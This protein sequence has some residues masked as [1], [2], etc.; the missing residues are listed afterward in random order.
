MTG[1]IKSYKGISP[2]IHESAFIAD[3]AVI[4]G[5]VEIGPESSIWY[6]CVLRGDLNKIRIGARTNI[7]DGTIIHV[8]AAT[9]NWEGIPTLIGDRVNVGHKAL[10]H[11][12]TVEDDAFIGMGSILLD[13]SLV[14]SGAMV[15]AGALVTPNKRVLKGELW[16]G[17]PAKCMRPL[18]PDELEYFKVVED[19]YAR[20]G[21]EHKMEQS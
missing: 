4:I 12:C 7:Q 1:I 18:K 19:T 3:N 21:A 20:L 13:G 9:E 17:S 5:D 8:D 10:I 2:K 11:A 6:N 14:E 15:A 16:G